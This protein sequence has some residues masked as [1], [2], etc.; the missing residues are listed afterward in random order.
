MAEGRGAAFRQRWLGTHFF[1]PPRY[2][3][4]LEVIPTTDTDAVDLQT[5][6][7][8]ADRRLGKGV[9]V[10]KDTP[11]FIANRLG[12]YGVMQVFQAMEAAGLTVEEVDAITGPAIG[13]PKSATFR[14]MDL[15]GID[16]LAAVAR[17]L[18]E[19]L[20]AAEQPAFAL[21]PVVEQLVARG[22]NGSKAGR[23]FYQKTES[24]DIETLDFPLMEYRPSE[25]PR[26][27]VDR[28][29]SEHRGPRPPHPR[30]VRRQGQG[31]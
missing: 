30:V 28:C 8:F 24:G 3:P 19:R 22:W 26:F 2:L 18:A 11:G 9:V 29:G 12:L 13:R 27:A 10:A 17:D 20:A 14:T 6:I 1:N 4:L 5:V 23:G 25:R 15:A 21:P 31:R 7:D 16:I